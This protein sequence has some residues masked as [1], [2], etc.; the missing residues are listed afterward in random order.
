MRPY[1]C[2]NA[3]GNVRMRLKG[4]VIA[5]AFI[6]AISIS[7]LIRNKPLGSDYIMQSSSDRIKIGDV[8]RYRMPTVFPKFQHE[9]PQLS[10]NQA[11]P[12]IEKEA[13][14]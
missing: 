8:D 2:L 4:V 3:K 12:E 7:F 6:V 13:L 11:L 5:L 10:V 9:N 1:S 14:I